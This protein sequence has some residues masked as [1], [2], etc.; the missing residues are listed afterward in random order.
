MTAH[1]NKQMNFCPHVVPGCQPGEH[2]LIA[3][4]QQ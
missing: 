3:G 1:A 2:L 4:Q